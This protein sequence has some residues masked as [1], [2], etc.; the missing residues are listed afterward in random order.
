MGAHGP[1][2]YEKSTVEARGYLFG[3]GMLNMDAP[4]WFVLKA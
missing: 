3:L 2:G 1:G 4:S